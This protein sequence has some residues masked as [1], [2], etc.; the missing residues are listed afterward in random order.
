MVRLIRAPPNPPAGTLTTGGSEGDIAAAEPADR[1]PTPA[2]ML[3]QM[4]R[5]LMTALALSFCSVLCACTGSGHYERRPGEVVIDV[6]VD[7]E[8]VSD[9]ELLEDPGAEPTGSDAN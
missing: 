2:A 1:R 9:V 5:R 6:H 8:P 7:G 4:K 3:V